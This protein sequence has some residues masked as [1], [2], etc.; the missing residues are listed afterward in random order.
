MNKLRI[1]LRDY[2]PDDT[3]KIVE[4]IADTEITQ[5]FTF[6]DRSLS[7]EDIEVFVSK[8]ISNTSH[9]PIFKN[10]VLFDTFELKKIYIGSVGLKNIDYKKNQAEVTIVISDKKYLGKGLGQEALQL[11]C[12]YGFSQLSLEKIEIHCIAENVRAIRAYEKFGFSHEKR[13]QRAILKHGSYYDEIIMCLSKDTF[14]NNAYSQE[15]SSQTNS[16]I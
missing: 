7:R 1:Q 8:Q 3:E 15:I 10:F 4:W 6:A 2:K 16:I 12:E 14:D 13:R 11:I 5:W 9:K